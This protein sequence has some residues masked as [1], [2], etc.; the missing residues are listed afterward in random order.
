MPPGVVPR[1]LQQWVLIAVALV[2]IGIMTLTNSP[3]DSRETI[4]M[5][6]TAPVV[7]ANQQRIEEYQRRIQEQAQRLAAEQAQLELTKQELA[8]TVTA[9]V[10]SDIPLTVDQQ[11]SAE[12]PRSERSSRDDDARFADNVAYSRPTAGPALPA[13]PNPLAI[14]DSSSSPALPVSP[15]VPAPRGLPAPPAVPGS[16][17]AP[18][19]LHRLYE[20]TVIETVLTNRLDST[21]NGPV[22][23]LVS[24][25]VYAADYQH[26]VIPAGAR[27]LGEARAVSAFGQSRLAVVFHRLLLPDGSSVNLNDFHGLNQV[28]DLGLEDQVD[29]HYG[30]IFG[31][32]LAIGVLAGFS[33]AQTAAG[34]NATGTDVYRQGAADSFSQSGMRILDRFLNVLPTIT[35]R[36]GHRM[37][38]YLSRDLELPAVRDPRRLIGG[39]P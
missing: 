25:P 14:P 22:N 19:R 31:T 29:R 38:V 4:S 16:P 39:R 21:F 23:G 3:S 35:I 7:D 28:G 5:T 2:M 6:G 12:A 24:V 13:A 33:Q 1:H 20:G 26:L 15:A 18:A 9:S 36:E 34:L 8:N 27:I 11:Q 37:K 30:R 32:S 17:G 10:P